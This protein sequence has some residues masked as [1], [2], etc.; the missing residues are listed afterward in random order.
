MM[1]ALAPK[2]RQGKEFIVC[3]TWKFTQQKAFSHMPLASGVE[4]LES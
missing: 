4:G 3:N 1:A 2:T